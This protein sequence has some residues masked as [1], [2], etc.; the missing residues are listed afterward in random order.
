MSTLKDIDYRETGL[1]IEY[2]LTPSKH[3]IPEVGEW[4]KVGLTLKSGREF[5]EVH[6]ETEGHEVSDLECLIHDLL[7]LSKDEISAL[8][9]EPIEPD[10]HLTIKLNEKDNSYE[11]WLV[12]DAEGSR[13]GAYCGKGL[14]IYLEVSREGI[15]DFA[16][17]LKTELSTVKKAYKSKSA[18]L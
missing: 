4:V 9:F 1:E 16:T 3:Y 10:Y 6:I 8:S 15:R 5:P 12:I 2:Q 18:A 17:H 13:G 7:K 11:L 14:A